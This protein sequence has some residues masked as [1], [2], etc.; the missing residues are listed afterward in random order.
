MPCGRCGDATGALAYLSSACALAP[1][2]LEAEAFLLRSHCL[3]QLGRYAEADAD[4]DA[5][6]NAIKKYRAVGIQSPYC[7]KQVKAVLFGRTGRTGDLWRRRTW[8][9][10]RGTPSP[11]LTT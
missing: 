6:I 9:W 8:P 5:V 1:D 2:A 11:W 3:C 4:A 10:R 7:A